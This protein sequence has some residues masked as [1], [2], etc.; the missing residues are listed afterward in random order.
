MICPNCK[1]SFDCPKCQYPLTTSLLMSAHVSPAEAKHV[2][3]E[4]VTYA[5]VIITESCFLCIWALVVWGVAYVLQRIEPHMPNWAPM[6]F[7]YVEIGFALFI[8]AKLFIARAEVFENALKHLR[9][10][11][12]AW[13]KH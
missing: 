1:E 4:L 2:A 3:A 13:T 11:M 7:R 8:L 12:A 6:M 10:V 5:L 9:R